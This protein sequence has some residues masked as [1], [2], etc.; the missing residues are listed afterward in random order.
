MAKSC[1]GKE[2]ISQ[3]SNAEHVLRALP[4]TKRRAFGQLNRKAGDRADAHGAEELRLDTCEI[5]QGRR[6]HLR[7]GVFEI[8]CNRPTCHCSPS[9]AIDDSCVRIIGCRIS[10]LRQSFDLCVFGADWVKDE[11]APEV[12][13][14]KCLEIETGHDTEI[15]GAAL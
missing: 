6:E 13:L 11:S 8:I 5:G 14:W 12:A 4:A 9:E 7:L 1:L 2:L 10:E 3:N 15:V